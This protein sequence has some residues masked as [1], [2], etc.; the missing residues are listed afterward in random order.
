MEAIQ[1]TG[2]LAIEHSEVEAPAAAPAATPRVDTPD[3]Y[4]LLVDAVH[5]PG[6]LAAAHQFFHNY[7]LANRWLASS[8]LRAAGLPLLPINTFKGWLSAERPVQKGQKA[9]IALIMPVPIRAKKGEDDEDE[10]GKG[11]VKFTKFMLRNY[12]FHLNQTDGKEYNPDESNRGDW[13]LTAAL[14]FLEIKESPFEF[15]SV[16][17]MRLGWAQGKEIAVSPLEVHQTYGRLREMARV[18][19]GHTAEEPAKSVPQE[20]SMR[21]IE[22]DTAAYLCAASLCIS[23]LEEAR[24]RL[25]VN[26][27]EGS[28]LRIPDKC[29]HRAFS[30]ADKLINAGYC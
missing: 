8:Q 11:K 16:S 24:L 1:Q 20:Q 2:V 15:A 23:G 28:K 26:L 9:S 7:S 5:E 12:W 14:D 18:L 19:L 30:A 13:N 6:Q 3:W 25:Q 27:A 21:D 22:A 4:E 29:A 17:D 10:K